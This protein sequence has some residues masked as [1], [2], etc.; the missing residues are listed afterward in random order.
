MGEP[1]GKKEM[2]S[3]ANVL[4]DSRANSVKTVRF[5]SLFL[6]SST[7]SYRGM[8][9]SSP[10]ILF[11]TW[12][13]P[14]DHKAFSPSSCTAFSQA[15]AVNWFWC[16]I[17]DERSGV[18]LFALARMTDP[19]R[20]T[21]VEYWGL[22]TVKTWSNTWESVVPLGKVYFRHSAKGLRQASQLYL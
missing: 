17:R 14:H 13:C 19:K 6:V 18:A 22:T 2:A 9:W 3:S 1:A 21:E 11:M 4:K 12:C 16:R 20:L 10:D 7:I 5:I 15:F 8:L